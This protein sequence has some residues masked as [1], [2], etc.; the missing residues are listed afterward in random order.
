MGRT[1]DSNK[2]QFFQMAVAGVYWGLAL[3]EPLR[4]VYELIRSLKLTHSHVGWDICEHLTSFLHHFTFTDTV[5]RSELLDRCNDD[6]RTLKDISGPVQTIF[7]FLCTTV[8]STFAQ[9]TATSNDDLLGLDLA[10]W[11]E[12]RKGM[13]RNGMP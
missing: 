2:T 8:G 10:N 1:T 12:G 5:D 13:Q 3:D 11:G 4:C 6:H 9:A 7:V